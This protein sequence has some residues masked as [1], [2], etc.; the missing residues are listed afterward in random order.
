VRSKL[1]IRSSG[2]QNRSSVESLA[3]QTP[4]SSV[5]TRQVLGFIDG[6]L[7]PLLKQRGDCVAL[8]SLRGSVD[9]DSLSSL[10][11]ASKTEIANAIDENLPWFSSTDRESASAFTRYFR[12]RSKP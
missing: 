6:T 10:P 4:E 7:V 3:E 5:P 8:H 1:S 12:P 2:V 9:L 11:M